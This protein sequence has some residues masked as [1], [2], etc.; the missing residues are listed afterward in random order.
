MLFLQATEKLGFGHDLKG[1]G[2]SRA[3]KVNK[4]NAGF[5]PRGMYFEIPT[6]N[7]AFFRSLFRPF[8]QQ[9]L[10]SFFAFFL[11]SSVPG[12]AGA[13]FSCRFA[14]QA[15]PESSRLQRDRRE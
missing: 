14:G 5:S 11:S 9:K 2:F 7:V 15:A 8:P 12:Q 1:H 10:L 6:R 4:I 3:D 13:P